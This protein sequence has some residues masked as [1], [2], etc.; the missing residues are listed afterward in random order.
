MELL[1]RI[2]TGEIQQCVHACG[3][4][5]VP[6]GVKLLK[7]GI[8]HIEGF[9]CASFFHG[10]KGHLRRGGVWMKPFVAGGYGILPYRE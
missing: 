2:A 3:P 4:F 5:G 10:K 6:W 1:Y 9:L 8:P 7:G